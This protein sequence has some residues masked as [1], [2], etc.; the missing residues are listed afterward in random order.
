MNS[1]FKIPSSQQDWVMLY[2][3]VMSLFVLQGAVILVLYSMRGFDTHPDAL[4]FLLRLDPM[5][6][7]IHLVTGLIGTYFAFWKPSRALTFLRAF[8]LF[9]LG[10]AFF[11]TFTNIHF[12]LYLKTEENLFHWTVTS[13]A[14]AISFGMNFLPKKA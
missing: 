9:Y 11:G 12:G 10:L 13:L 3:K 5:H 2:C 14:A 8:T 7:V 6:G 1:I 4:P